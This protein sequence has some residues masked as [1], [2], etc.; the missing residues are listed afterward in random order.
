MLA[1]FVFLAAVILDPDME[2]YDFAEE[3]RVLVQAVPDCSD[4]CLDQEKRSVAGFGGCILIEKLAEGFAF[5][6]SI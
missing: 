3:W 6:F 1:D 2:L 5:L 4:P